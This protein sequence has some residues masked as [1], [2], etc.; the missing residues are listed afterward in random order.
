MFRAYGNGR[1]QDERLQETARAKYVCVCVEI[2]QKTV[3]YS[4]THSQTHIDITL[5]NDST[6]YT[7]DIV[8]KKL[9]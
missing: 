4:H 7:L 5:D 9:I 2:K 6:R 1:K 3:K 8:S